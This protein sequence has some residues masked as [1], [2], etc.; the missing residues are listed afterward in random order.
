MASHLGFADCH[1]DLLLGVSAQRDLGNDDL[2]GEFWLPQLRA[3]NVRL[4]VLPIYTEDWFTGEAALRRALRTVETARQIAE[5][6]EAAVALVTTA[7]ELHGALDAGRIALVLAFEGMEPVGA[8]LDLIDTFWH[9]GVRMASLTWNRR[10]PFA[11]GLG[12]R[13]TGA[14]LTELGVKAVE[15]MERLGMIVDVSHLADAGY[16]HIA[17]VATRPFVASHSSCRDVFDHPRNLR[18][19]QLRT[20]ADRGGFV[21]MNAMADFV[22][23]DATIDTYL[24][25]VEHAVRLVGAEHVGLGL[26]FLADTEAHSLPASAQPRSGSFISSLERPADLPAL[27][28]R[29]EQRLGRDTARTVAS[30]SLIT[31]LANL[32]PS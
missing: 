20:I 5:R 25:H 19:D 32:L 14:G 23:E 13:S 29:L 16:D 9:L 27:G 2:F 26:D 4:V 17:R 21:G 24:D 30:D 3:G 31:A 28:E 15:R 7:A 12:E 6:Y 8:D 1:N 22:G 10:T 11:D 18:D